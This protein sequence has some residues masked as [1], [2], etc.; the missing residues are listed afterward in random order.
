M[1]DSRYRRATLA[2]LAAG[3]ATFSSL[4]CTQALLPALSDDFGISAAQSALTVSAATGALAL[5]VVPAS[6]LSERF[7]RGRVLVWSLCAAALVGLALPFAP[8]F[9]WLVALRAMQGMFIAGVPAVAMAWLAEELP[10]RLNSAMGLYIAG[11]SIGGLL[12]R[13]IPSGMLELTDWRPALAATSVLSFLCWMALLFLLPK[14]LH[15]H[16]RSLRPKAEARAMLKHWKDPRLAR[17]F[18]IPFI[19]MGVFVSLYNYV[20][21]HMISRY[22]LSPALVGVLF[23]MYL[24]GTWSS[25]AAGRLRKPRMALIAALLPLS[26]VL[27][28]IPSLVATVAAILVFTASFFAVRSLASARVG[29]IATHHRAEASS[30]YIFC[31]YFGSSVLGWLSGHVFGFGWPALIWW[32]AGLSLI[33][34]FLAAGLGSQRSAHA[35]G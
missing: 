3:L 31:Y 29:K 5:C 20:G 23:I 14:Q 18:V 8:T 30:M 17:L 9:W 32:L 24:S 26:L 25:A 35:Y 7:G 28:L 19:S 10:D 15:F 21:Y 4:Y 12:G 22:H 11:N 16:A 34:C 6:I 2:M 13:L 1:T 33:A 27:T